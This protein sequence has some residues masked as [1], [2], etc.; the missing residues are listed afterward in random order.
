L[1]FLDCDLVLQAGEG[2]TN[3]VRASSPEGEA[4]SRIKLALTDAAPA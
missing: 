3:E 4:A 2:A 1:D